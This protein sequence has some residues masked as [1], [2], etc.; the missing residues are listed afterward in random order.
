MYRCEITN[1]V[2]EPGDPLNKIVALTRPKTYFRWIKNEENNRW[3]E[4]E[5]GH[6]SEV[7]RELSL[8]AEGL[9]LWHSWSDVDRELFL[10]AK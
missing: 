8:S 3:E 7:V 5:V 2:S 10:K 9:Q 4:V 1:K 6:G